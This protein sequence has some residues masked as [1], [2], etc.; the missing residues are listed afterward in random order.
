[1]LPLP[2][3]SGRVAAYLTWTAV[4]PGDVMRE[5]LVPLT[6]IGFCVAALLFGFVTFYLHSVAQ[7]LAASQ[8]RAQEL[9]GR[10]PLSGLAN[11]LLFSERLDRE[12][13]ILSSTGQGLAVLFIDLDRIKDVNDTMAIR[14]GTISFSSSPTG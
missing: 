14:R 4:R 10:D 3:G 8:A 7:D 11:R 5:R 1:M 6:L 2:D 9:L 13:E 12:L